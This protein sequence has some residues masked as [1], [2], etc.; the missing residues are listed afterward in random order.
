MFFCSLVGAEASR[1]ES[2]MVTRWTVIKA[3]LSGWQ[4][5]LICDRPIS[6]IKGSLSNQSSV[7]V[8]VVYFSEHNPNSSNI[9]CNMWNGLCVMHYNLFHSLQVRSAC[10][11]LTSWFLTGL[12]VR[13]D[14]TQVRVIF[15]FYHQVTYQRSAFI[16][17][18]DILISSIFITL[19]FHINEPRCIF[20]GQV[21]NEVPMKALSLI[22]YCHIPIVQNW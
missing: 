16:R 7:R 14:F 20:T 1:F 21:V 18:T 15:F 12:P 4:I 2:S 9:N 17:K 10:F 8:R 19:S 3:L 6:D 11:F 5:K 22:L 13:G